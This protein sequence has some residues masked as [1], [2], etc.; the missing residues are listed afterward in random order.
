MVRDLQGWLGFAVEH[1]NLLN[2]HGL[3]PVVS[4]NGI[5]GCGTSSIFAVDKPP[6]GDDGNADSLSKTCDLSSS[7]CLFF[8]FFKYIF[9]DH[10]R[11]YAEMKL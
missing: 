10:V 4:V 9:S 7:R 8:K 1:G 6:E 3:F 5:P 11:Y 2:Q